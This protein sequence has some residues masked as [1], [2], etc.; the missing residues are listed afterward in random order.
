[1]TASP[2]TAPIVC[3]GEILVDLIA[4]PGESLETATRF[5]IREGGAPMNAAVAIARLG[6]PVRFCG[7]VGDD[8]FGS[9]LRR[10]L[11]AEG[12]D[13]SALRAASGEPTSIAYAWRDERGDGHFQLIRLADRLLSP[14]DLG[15]A[16]VESASALLVGSVALA[17]EPSRSAIT[18]AV[19]T[20]GAAGVP[21]VFDINVRPTLWADDAGLTS[22]CDPVLRAA[23]LIKVSLDDARHLWKAETADAVMHACRRYPCRL[24]VITDGA[25]GVAVGDPHGDDVR[26]FPVEPVD[27]IDPTGAGDAFTAALVTRMVARGWTSPDDDDIRFAMAAGALATTKQGALPALPTLA[28]LEHFQARIQHADA[29]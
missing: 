6:N 11:E 2:A 16:G 14:A 26:Q 25:R 15:A 19:A 1:M 28:E 22:A 5:A 24:V 4:D 12:V 18:S 13:A 23:T 29:E 10:L 8:Q 7:V 20:A 9:R 21:V 17:A 27:A 3:A